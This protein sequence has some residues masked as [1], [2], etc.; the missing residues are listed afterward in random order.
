M[1]FAGRFDMGAIGRGI[2]HGLMDWKSN[3]PAR[4]G[5][6]AGLAVA[7]AFQ[8]LRLRVLGST[9]GK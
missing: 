1:G 9:P 3:A 8:V 5:V 2:G 4:S 6:P 7:I